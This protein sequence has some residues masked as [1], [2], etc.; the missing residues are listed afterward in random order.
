MSKRVALAIGLFLSLLVAPPSFAGPPDT[1]RI[2][3]AVKRALPLLERA[4][5]GSAEHRK[6]FT[7]HSQALPIFALAEA[8]RRGFDVD[9]ENLARQIEHTFKHLERGRKQYEEGKGQGGG[10]DTAGYALWSLEEGEAPDQDVIR[11]VTDWLIERQ[12]ESGRWKCTS[13]RPPT[14]A[15]HF[16]TTYL[17]LRA[18]SYFGELDQQPA[19]E[20]AME[21]AKTWLLD[22]KAKDTEDS[23][24][25][26]LA[27]NYLPVE[28]DQVEKA[29]GDLWSLQ[30]D[31]GGWAQLEKMESDPYATATALH[32]L[33]KAG[34]A[35]HDDP[36]LA[37]GIE[38][39]M[40]HQLDDGSWLVESRSK[41]FQTYF[42]TGF[43]HGEDQFIST[44]AT[45]WAT[46]VLL[47][48][49]EPIERPAE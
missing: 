15:S 32:A 48:T 10:V 43:P 1:S 33:L 35:E 39:L 12:E 36:G 37:R 49:I 7:C 11:S 46:L 3:E 27:F 47:E 13:N 28:R 18:L 44:M 5:A 22:N 26:L 14:E 30:Q 9:S 25:R 41:P 24:F 29:I 16:T 20:A 17:A 45:A 19:I 38:F 2:H 8:R 21:S 34:G 4:S 42:E 6:C 31:D 23:V 40:D